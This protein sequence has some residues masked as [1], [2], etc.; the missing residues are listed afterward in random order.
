[1]GWK[2]NADETERGKVCKRARKEI[3]DVRNKNNSSL[4]F[5]VS[6]SL[7]NVL[8]SSIQRHAK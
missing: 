6:F 5:E 2:K 3:N 7:V 8:M 1:M 4:N